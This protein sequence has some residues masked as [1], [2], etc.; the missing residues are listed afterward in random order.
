[1]TYATPHVVLDYRDQPAHSRFWRSDTPRGTKV[2][3]GY[4][5][6]AALL[7]WRATG[8]LLSS[9]AYVALVSGLWYLAGARNGVPWGPL[10]WGALVI[11]PAMWLLGAV[12]EGRQGL[13][14]HVD[15]DVLHVHR[16]DALT[17]G[18]W[19]RWHRGELTRA[20][21]NWEGWIVLCGTDGRCVA[22]LGGVGATRVDME[23]LARFIRGRLALDE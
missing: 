20:Y 3:A 4:I 14:V 19:R 21:V 23:W 7:R 5:G 18:R 6:V 8:L 13:C 9:V 10:L 2:A 11:N 17:R 16:Q 15:G 12:M 22:K 1:M